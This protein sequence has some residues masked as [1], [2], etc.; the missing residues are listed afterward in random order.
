MDEEGGGGGS[1]EREIAGHKYCE[2]VV[3]KMGGEREE[4]AEGDGENV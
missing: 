2:G 4:N 1:L 3:G